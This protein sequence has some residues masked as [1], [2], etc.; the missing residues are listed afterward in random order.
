MAAAGRKSS[1]SRSKKSAAPPPPVFTTWRALY[2]QLLND[3]ASKAF[4]TMQSYTVNT[5][6]IGGGR[7]VT[8]RGLAELLKFMEYAKEQ[9]EIE[10]GMSY[11]GRTYAG[12]GG[13][14]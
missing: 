3:L 13:R 10:E 8:Y 5:G 2:D 6:G 12:N 4:R 11:A 1:V 9:A 14:G 7:T